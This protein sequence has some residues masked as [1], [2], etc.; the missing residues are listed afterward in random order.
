MGPFSLV[1][2]QIAILPAIVMVDVVMVKAAGDNRYGWRVDATRVR[3]GSGNAVPG[4]GFSTS[5]YVFL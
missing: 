4:D 5:H 3:C 1:V 2:Q